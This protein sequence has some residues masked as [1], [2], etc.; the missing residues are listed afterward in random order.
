MTQLKKPTPKQIAA[1]KKKIQEEWSELTLRKRSGASGE[2]WTPPTVK[3]LKD[4]ES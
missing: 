2:E 4:G 3:V 1:R